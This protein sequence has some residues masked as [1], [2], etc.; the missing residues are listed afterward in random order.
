MTPKVP[1][2]YREARRAQILD[3]A[4]ECF[5]EKGFHQTTM[6]DIFRASGLS[7]GA[8][9]NYFESKDDIVTAMGEI[10]RNR[11]VAMV[12]ATPGPDDEAPLAKI[13][14]SFFGIMNTPDAEKWAPL[15]LEIY[16]EAARNERIRKSIADNVRMS[17]DALIPLVE[18]L[19]ARGAYSAD[20]DARSI[21]VAF[22]MLVQGMQIL[23]VVDPKADLDA[24]VEVC[25]AIARGTFCA[26]PATNSNSKEA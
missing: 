20:L 4:A 7:A 18:E 25:L 10:S 26:A 15:D 23:H 22:S 13:L 11:N 6:Q 19:Q 1:E 16:A 8:V 21:I 14:E 9:Y 3:A 17:S 12:S 2:N 24:Y 5:L